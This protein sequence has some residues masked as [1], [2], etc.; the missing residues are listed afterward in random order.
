MQVL[1]SSFLWHVSLEGKTIGAT[2]HG[3]PYAYKVGPLKVANGV[4]IYNPFKLP[5]KWVTWVITL[6]MGGPFLSTYNWTGAH[7]VLGL[8]GLLGL[9]ETPHAWTIICTKTQISDEFRRDFSDNFQVSQIMTKLHP[10]SLEAS[11]L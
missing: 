7:L 3:M 8:L 2:S 9:W 4:I 6:L 10:C 5:Y 1:P 11:L